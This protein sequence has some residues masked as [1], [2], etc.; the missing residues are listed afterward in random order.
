ME[1]EELIRIV[2]NR[3][4]FGQTREEI[5]ESLTKHGVE[6]EHFGLIYTAAELLEKWSNQ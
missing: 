6:F 3:I 5:L 2:R 4:A 1:Q